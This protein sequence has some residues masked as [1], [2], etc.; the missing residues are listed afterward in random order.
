MKLPGHVGIIPDGNRRWASRRGVGLGEAY[1]MGYRRLRETV[2]EL[3]RL[4]IRN[5]SVYAMSRDNCV[6]RGMRELALLHN[7]ASKA[8]RELRE[9]KRLRDEDI[10][11]QVLGDLE[12]LPVEVR[13]EALKTVRATSSRGGGLL[14]IAL[15][16]SGR[17]EVEY[18]TSRGL[19]PPT[20]SL[21]GVDLLI[22]TGGYRRISSFLPLL[23][24]YAEMYF[25]TTL[26]PDFDKEELAKA[27]GWF[28]AQQRKFGK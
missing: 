7:L 27:L 25:T 4:G 23:L 2:E 9:D 5:V 21:P 24:E 1:E 19:T 11:I 6:K 8:F 17:W 16:Y 26:W 15:C 20:L 18:Y 10:R 28:S 14:L 13:R 22:R 12:L 3:N